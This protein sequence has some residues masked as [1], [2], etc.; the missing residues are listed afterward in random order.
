MDLK[1]NL[2]F[3]FLLLNAL[4]LQSQISNFNEKFVL[5][6]AVKENSGLLFLDGKIITHNDSGDA[7][8]LYEIDLLSGN[9]LRTITISNATNIDWE[10]ISEDEDHIYIADIGNNNGNRTD[11]KIYKIL[12]SDFRNNTSVTA[13]E[14]GFSYEDQTDFSSQEDGSNFDAEAM[15]VYNNALFIFTKNWQNLQTNVYK[16]PLDPGN[17]SALKVS[18]ANINGLITGAS[19]YN[20][21][22]LLCGYSNTLI[23]FVVHIGHDRTPG[24]DIFSSGFT[25]TSLEEELEQGSQVEAIIGFDAGKYYI[26]RE[27][28]SISLGGNNIVFPQKLYEFSDNRNQVLSTH[29]YFKNTVVYPNPV[30]DTLQFNFP[31][32]RIAIYNSLG[33]EV[34]NYQY[35]K[36]T[37]DVSKFTKGTYFIVFHL[38]NNTNRSVKILKK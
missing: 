34:K 29:E 17:H 25:K 14:I 33:V 9:L 35:H 27:Y 32:N 16:V 1:K 6:D 19:L 8:N 23:P 12:K 26:S 37:I 22:F 3:Y 5:P 24:D 15:V 30:V 18:D 7:A 4:L 36:K 13:E 21:N 2:V 38:E 31:F 11:L 28:F 10:D 20:N